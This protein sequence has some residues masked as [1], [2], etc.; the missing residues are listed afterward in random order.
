[1][2]VVAVVGMPGAGKSV[3]AG[4][5]EKNGFRRIRFGDITDAEVT[6]RGLV[7]NEANERR[8][9][10]ELRK[11]HGMA[12][13]AK[14]NIPVINAALKSTAVVID[15]LYS[16]EEYVLLKDYYGED[17]K[18]VA[19]WTSPATRYRRLGIRTNRPLTPD[20]AAA[21]DKSEI[22]NINKGGPIAM[23]DFTIRNESTVTDLQKETEEVISQLQ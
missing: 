6:R 3:V 2:K 20:E 23:A 12:A 9:R 21:R 22:E 11:E 8:V 19:V 17:L 5:F 16:W 7:L 18:V 14:L 15:G 13:Y 4:V 1:M 10:E